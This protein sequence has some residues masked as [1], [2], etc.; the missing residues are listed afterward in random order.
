MPK[1]IE[2]CVR[3]KPYLNP[4]TEQQEELMT[5]VAKEI[6]QENNNN[7]GG[8]PWGLLCHLTAMTKIAA[9][10]AFL[11]LGTTMAAKNIFSAFI[12]GGPVCYTDN[13]IAATAQQEELSKNPDIQGIAVAMSIGA[14]TLIQGTF[15]LDAMKTLYGKLYAECSESVEKKVSRFLANLFKKGNGTAEIPEYLKEYVLDKDKHLLNKNINRHEKVER[16]T[17]HLAEYPDGSK[18]FFRS[19]PGGKS[20]SRNKRIKRNTRRRKNFHTWF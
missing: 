10:G 8:A 1:P 16:R 17:S 5:A 18:P 15:T 19:V 4:N 20:K 14:L 9:L 2:E 7:S 3:L 11:G 12:Q 6:S 13:S